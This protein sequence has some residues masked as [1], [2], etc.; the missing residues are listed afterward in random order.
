MKKIF[1]S[2]LLLSC[3]FGFSQTEKLFYFVESDSLVGVKN[4]DGKIIIPA[5]YLFTQ[6]ASDVNSKEEIKDR[7]LFSMPIKEGPKAHDRKGN[8][9]FEPY[10]FDAGIDYFSEGYMRFTENK[11]VGFAD[12]NGVKIIPAKYDWVSAMNFGFAEFCNGCHFDTSKDPEHPPLV[13][14][15][16]GF[17]NKNGVEIVPTD[18]RNHPK[19]FETE[20]HQFIPY[21]FQYNEKEKQILD[22]FEKR[23]EQIAQIDDFNCNPKIIY[24]EIVEKPS[25]FDP[26]YKVK[27]F[28]LCN[29]YLR[30]SDENY[31]DF[32]NFKVSQDGKDFY[33]TYIELVD[34]KKY[35]EY[36][37][38]KIPV[39]KWIKQNLKKTKK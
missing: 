2:L 21:Q 12:K 19:D 27:T 36:V 37:E 17:V 18:K 13:G 35:S 9:L 8:F 23:K 29:S 25:E 33:V 22:F 10:I 3:L 28:E 1:V 38:R 7:I 11:K 4:Q 20:K 32:K 24:F 14:G 6:S 39:D 16:W 5:K 34:H 15:T 30:G 26:F 31:D